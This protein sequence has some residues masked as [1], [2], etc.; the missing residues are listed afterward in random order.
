VKFAKYRLERDKVIQRFVSKNP[1]EVPL[2]RDYVA[3]IAFKAFGNTVRAMK[4]VHVRY[5]ASIVRLF[6]MKQFS[7]QTEQYIPIDSLGTRQRKILS[8]ERES[9]EVKRNELRSETCAADSE[10]IAS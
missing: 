4:L 2:D 10:G 5:T 7:I 6:E 3:S 1:S 8:Q 9:D